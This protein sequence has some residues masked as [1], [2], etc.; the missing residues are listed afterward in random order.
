[1]SHT[2]EI[3]AFRM[4]HRRVSAVQ[5]DECRIGAARRTAPV[6]VMRLARFDTA[7]ASE[8]M[9]CARDRPV[10]LRANGSGALG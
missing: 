3:E 10:T 2:N 8:L 6:A 9:F 1:M 5:L 7:R 4:F